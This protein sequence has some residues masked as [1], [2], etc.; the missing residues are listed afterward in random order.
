[1]RTPEQIITD[2]DRLDAIFE[3]NRKDM[4]ILY[5]ERKALYEE[6]ISFNRKHDVATRPD[7]TTPF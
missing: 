7:T 6:L 3:T 1:M 4:A 2:I 5:Q